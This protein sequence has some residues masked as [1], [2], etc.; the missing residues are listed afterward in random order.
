MS[1]TQV[2]PT[3]HQ[4]DDN[5]QQILAAMVS[6]DSDTQFSVNGDADPAEILHYL[7]IVTRAFVMV[8]M[9]R[10]ALLQ[11]IGKILDRCKNEPRIYQSIGYSSFDLFLKRH[12]TKTLGLG[13]TTLRLALRI[14]EAFPSLPPADAGQVG[15]ANMSVCAKI[16][17]ETQPNHMDVIELAKT[18]SYGEMLEIAAVQGN[19]PP[20]EILK[21]HIFIRCTRGQSR[22]WKEFKSTP[23]VQAK[24]QTEDD[25]L[26]L[27]YMIAEVFNEW[28]QEE[29]AVAV[30]EDNDGAEQDIAF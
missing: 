23:R 4:L 7:Y 11:V 25:G 18:K 22:L 24:C 16:T 26:I 19:L 12:V 3:G 14:F 17:D 28:T 13:A 27:E 5:D 30:L 20:D 21:S 29:G 10:G 6:P 2:I 15:V 9:R 1:T 8:D